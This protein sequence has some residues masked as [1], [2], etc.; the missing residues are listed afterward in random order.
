MTSKQVPEDKRWDS[1]KA[2]AVVG[3]PWDPTPTIDTE[4]RARVPSPKAA[5]AEVIPKDPEIPEIVAR[6]MYIRKADI[7]KYSETPGCVGCRCIVR[8]KSL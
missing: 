2:L 3:M 8:G 1:A 5:D 4:D 6:R 7:M